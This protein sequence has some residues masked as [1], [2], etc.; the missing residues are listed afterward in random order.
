MGVFDPSVF[1]VLVSCVVFFG[2]TLI[3]LRKKD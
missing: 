3:T 1:G 2:L